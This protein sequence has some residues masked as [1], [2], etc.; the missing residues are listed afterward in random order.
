MNT[1][2]FDAGLSGGQRSNRV[3]QVVLVLTLLSALFL[4]LL[5]TTSN[6]VVVGMGLGLVGGAFLLAAPRLV[7]WLVLAL[8]L[9]TGAL[10]SIAGPAYIKLPW[11]ISLMTFLL[12]PMALLHMTQRK[13]LPLFIW[14]AFT[15]VMV[16]V[17]TTAAQWYSLSEF[18]AGFKRYFQ[19]YGLLFALAAL[20]FTF[21]DMRR[22]QKLLLA[23]ALLQLPF[24]IYE[25]LV[26]VPLRGG[27]ESG[28]SAATDVVAGTF[29][30]NLNGGS[31]NAE[32]AAFLVIML[33]FLLSRW[34][35]G[36]MSGGTALLLGALCTIPLGLGETK[37]VLILIPLAGAILLRKDF[38]RSPLRY[39][40]ALL[41]LMLVTAV[42]GWIYISVMMSS[43]LEFVLEN[44]FRY[45]LESVGYGEA[46]LNRTSVM[47]FWW[48][49]HGWHDPVGFLFGHGIGSAFWAP[50]NPIAGHIGMHFPRYSIDLTTISSLLWDTGLVGLVLYLSMMLF[51][52]VAANRLWRESANETV[53][54]DALA[55]QAAIAVFVLFLFYSSSA[56]NLLPFQI[57]TAA[58]LGY[59]AF[60]FRNA[61]NEL[62]KRKPFFAYGSAR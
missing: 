56:V 8:S 11:S 10:I 32:M 30:A 26:L 54:A 60:L 17:L 12:W 59:L 45:N 31:A 4:G 50:N 19:A 62:R 23:I 33:G 49:R 2:T 48:E 16:S 34:R 53:R 5:A 37:I 61:K 57:F 20:P 18:L 51:A 42:L 7:V 58:V 52:W 46:L 25:F 38:F 15:F 40:P 1:S 39:L 21:D 41:L 22:W 44:T 47:T 3:L 36:L 35:A 55:I 29:G 24:A 14:L 6:L 27:L 28:G 9:S 13:R 43:T